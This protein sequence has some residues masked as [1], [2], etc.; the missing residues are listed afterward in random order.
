MPNTRKVL[1]VGAGGFIGGFIAAESLRRGYDTYVAV[2]ESTSRRY[3]TD[4]RLRFVILDYDDPDQMHEALAAALPSGERWDY[5]IY[6]LGATKCA[7]FLDFKQ[8]NFEYLRRFCETIKALDLAPAKLLY[9]SSLSVL[10]PW[11]ERDNTPATTA[12]VP[13]PNTAYGLSKVQAESYLQHISGLPYIIFRATGVYGPRERDYLMMIKSIDRHW[14]F[15][16]GFRPQRLTFIYVNDLVNAMFDALAADGTTGHIYNISEER[17][18]SQAEFRRIVSEEL[19]GR[20][21]IPVR[22]PMFMVYAASAV[23]E[24]LA[25]WQ[26]KAS[27]L[28]RDKY[29]IMKQRNWRCDVSDAQR[30]FG[31]RTGY[32]LRRGIHET[33]AAYL[34]SKGK[35]GR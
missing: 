23:A 24:K 29:K 28:N 4:G 3:L 32:P 10:G 25:R 27:T 22:L 16:V 20:F 19:G 6:N 9:M 2:R 14:D 5:I 12:T 11:D 1:V 35:G 18:Y 33:V 21:V 31:F 34:D 26:G 13:D 8:I 7:N 17:D 15:G 30:D